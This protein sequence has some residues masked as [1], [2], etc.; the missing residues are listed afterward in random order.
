MSKRIYLLT[1]PTAVGKTEIALSWAET[2]GAEI[3]SCDS[4][5][6]YRGMNVGT[7]KPDRGQQER[8]SHHC[9]DLVPVDKRFSVGDYIEAASKAISG[10]LHRGGKV[11]VTGGSGFY[12]KSFFAPV[13]DHLSIPNPL[14]ERVEQLYDRE[15]L[16]GILGKL[17]EIDPMADRSIDVRN[18]RRVINALKRCLASGQSVEKLKKRFEKGRQPFDEFEILTCCLWRRID[19]LRTRVE[20]RTKDMLGRGLIEEVEVLLKEGLERNESAALAIGYRETIAFLRKKYGIGELE[21]TINRNTMRLIKKQ[22]NW[23]RGQLPIDHH[24]EL[25]GAGTSGEIGFFL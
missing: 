20:R 19:D 18:P 1:G 11:L 12:L 21:E 2:E 3:V 16:E 9:I 4:L 14:N 17:M 15:G 6:V 22:R 8:V 10:I 25:S 7:A 24:C 23:F 13:I 5:L